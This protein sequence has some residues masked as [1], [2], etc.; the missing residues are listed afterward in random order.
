MKVCLINPILFSFQRV[1]SRSLKNNVGMSFYPPLGLCYIANVLEKNGIKVEIIDRNS[2]MTKN[3]SDQF[4]VDNITEDQIR[5]FKPDIVGISVTTPTF[6]DVR[7]NVVKIIRKIDDKIR[8]VT[9]GPHVSALPEDT[10]RNCPEIDIVCRGEGELVMLE[11]AQGDKLLDIAGLTYRDGNNIVN[12]ID[13]T[14]HNNIDDFCSPA[15]HLVDMRYYSSPNPHVMHGLY[16]KATTIFTTRGCPYDC[17]FCAGSIALGRGVRFQSIELVIEEIKKLI[18][19]YRIEALYFADDMFDIKKERTANLCREL[20]KNN[21]NKKVRWN[22]Q[23]RANSMDKELL[24]LMKEAGCIRVDIGFESGSQKTLDIINKRTTVEQNYEAA[25]LLHQAGI[26]V[27]ANMIVGLPGEDRTDL[28]STR[29]FMKEIRPDW[30]GFGEFIPLPGSK[31][32]DDLIDKKLIKIESIEALEDLNL[33][34]VD[35]E[36]FHEFVKNV[37]DKIV[38]PLR[39]RNYIIHNWKK[40]GAF[41]YMLK[42][43]L[44][45]IRDKFKTGKARQ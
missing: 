21:I 3:H 32:F 17:T 7:C 40:P 25:R 30:I 24:K 12:N 14:P 10:L 37:R 4:V 44:G 18:V 19:D 33:T 43:I 9:G 26:Q 36:Y 1:E 2:L 34:K 39:L 23:L 38:N 28:N 8:I 20:I 15:R 6:F 45:S 42:I 27:H 16:F 5:K 11:I 13:R 29:D 35:D 31:L 22:A 41:L